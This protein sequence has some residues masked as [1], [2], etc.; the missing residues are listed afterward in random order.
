MHAPHVSG[1]HACINTMLARC[2]VVCHG[3]GECSSSCKGAEACSRRAWSLTGES[4][5]GTCK[6]PVD[7]SVDQRDDVS[8]FCFGSRPSGGLKRGNAQTVLLKRYYQ[9]DHGPADDR[10]R[11]G[12]LAEKKQRLSMKQC[13][14]NHKVRRC[15]GPVASCSSPQTGFDRTSVQCAAALVAGAR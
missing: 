15:Q 8:K 13:G 7:R 1:G 11:P 4:R 14:L 5:R 3:R 2:D 9:C 6:L 12:A 10:L